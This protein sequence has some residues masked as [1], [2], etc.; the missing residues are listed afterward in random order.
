M[1]TEEC[2]RRVVGFPAYEV[3]DFGHVRNAKNGRILKS[4][5]SFDRLGHL[6]S[7]RVGLT[8]SLKKIIT[9]SVHSLVLEAF[10]G[11]RPIGFMCRHL[12][13]NPADNRVENLKW[14]TAKENK[15]DSIA[16]G[17]SKIPKSSGR[18]R[19]KLDE[20][21]VRC[22]KAEPPFRGVNV[23]LAKAFGV[24]PNCVRQLRI[25]DSP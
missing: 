3:S 23:M 9:R 20:D 14:G 25:Q 2:W 13:G 5:F 16:H 22:I 12:N 8:I 18:P 19:W 17:I 11:P 1:I 6:N 4:S 10:V 24:T 21:D 7:L 15:A